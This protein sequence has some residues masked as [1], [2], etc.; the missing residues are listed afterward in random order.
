MRLQNIWLHLRLDGGG[1]LIYINTKSHRKKLNILKEYFE[2][3]IQCS[4]IKHNINQIL[5]WN[6]YILCTLYIELVLCLKYFCLLFIFGCT[7]I[8]RQL[9]IIWV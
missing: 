4:C 5:K 6:K 7:Y 3:L 9:F 8:F 1:N 2:Y